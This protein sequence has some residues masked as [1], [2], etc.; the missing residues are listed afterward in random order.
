[1]QSDSDFDASA[2]DKATAEKECLAQNNAWTSKFTYSFNV[3]GVCKRKHKGIGSFEITKEQCE[4][5]ASQTHVRGRPYEYN[6]ECK[7]LNKC[8][9]KYDKSCDIWYDYCFCRRTWDCATCSG[10]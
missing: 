2:K 7:E 1:M 6:W 10:R 4:H 3:F 9:G 8:P 5:W